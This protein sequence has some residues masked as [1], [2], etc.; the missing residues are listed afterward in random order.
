MAKNAPD[1]AGDRR[2]NLRTVQVII[3]QTDL[4]GGCLG[5]GQ[6]RPVRP[7]DR[8]SGADLS[9]EPVRDRVKLPGVPDDQGPG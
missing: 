7:D 6:D 5:I 8:D 1:A 2:L 3:H 9:G 4:V